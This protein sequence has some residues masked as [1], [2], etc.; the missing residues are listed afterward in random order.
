MPNLPSANVSV[1]EVGPRDGLQNE[2]TEVSVN[3]RSAF[4]DRL[5]SAGIKEI[6]GG[7]FVHPKVRQMMGSDQVFERLS[8]DSSFDHSQRRVWALVPNLTGM[9]RAKK[10]GV[11]NVAV[12]TAASNTFNERNIGTNIDGSFE[13]IAPVVAEAQKEHLDLRGYISTAFVCPFE[14]KIAPE[15]VGEVVQRLVDLGISNIS[16]G[17]TIGKATPDMVRGLLDYLFVKWTPGLFAMHFHETYGSALAGNAL[18]NVR[19]ALDYE[20][21]KFDA[22]AGGLGGCPYAPGASGNVATNDLVDMLERLGFQTGI[23]LHKLNEATECIQKILGR[24][25]PSKV[26]QEYMAEKTSN[27]V[28]NPNY[29]K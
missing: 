21:R 6:E 18:E 15:K 25:L 20:V 27:R 7:A 13:R 2:P 23:S 10:V 22:S 29:G 26:F 17:D 9:E 24:R 1:F 3:D 16:L 14:G 12:F 11:E 4:I 5:F 28:R 8:I 19:V